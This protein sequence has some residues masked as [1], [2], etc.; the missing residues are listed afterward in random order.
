MTFE[1]CLGFD[2]RTIRSQ[3]DAEE[4]FLAS[5]V[6]GVFEQL[7]TVPMIA[8]RF[9]DDEVFQQNNAAAFRCADGEEQIN[10]S[11]DGI[12]PS[13]NK[14]APSVRL[15]ENQSQAA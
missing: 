10:H 6:D 9:V 5:K 15:F 12:I 8:K 3:G 1:E 14:N 13:E 11:D 4:I 2:F 7:R